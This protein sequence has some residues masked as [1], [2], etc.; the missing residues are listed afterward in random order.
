MNK[1]Q[2]LSHGNMKDYNQRGWF[3]FPG[4]TQEDYLR[5]IEQ[6]NHF[7]SYPPKD[8]DNFLTDGEWEGARKRLKQ[9]YHVVPESIVAHYSDQGIGFLQGALMWEMSFNGLTVPLIQLKKGFQ[10]KQLCGMYSLDEV[11]AH[12]TIHAMRLGFNKDVFEEFF[13]YKAS[14]GRLR[15]FLGPLFQRIWEPYLFLGLMVIALLP[16]FISLTIFP[17]SFIN[18]VW[19]LPLLYFLYLLGRLSY[20]WTLLGLATRR[21]KKL[22]RDDREIDPLLFRMTGREIKMCALKSKKWSGYLET[23]KR[24]TFRWRFLYTLY[25]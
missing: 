2:Q 25:F 9:L 4:E 15:R 22:I 13:A 7:F 8:I 1:F 5:R 20:C 6:W 18:V 14:K 10:Y 19:A 16:F 12:E 3:P 17:L 11:L 24:A 23:E 21:L